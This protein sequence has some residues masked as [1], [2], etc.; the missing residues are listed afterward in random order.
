MQCVSGSGWSHLAARVSEAARWE[1]LKIYS[2]PRTPPIAAEQIRA[3]GIR[4]WNC[5]QV[6]KAIFPSRRI[7]RRDL[8][9][10]TRGKNRCKC[11]CGIYAQ[12]NGRVKER[13]RL[14]VSCWQL[15]FL[16]VYYFE[17]HQHLWAVGIGAFKSRLLDLSAGA[18]RTAGNNQIRQI[19]NPCMS[20][21]SR[22]ILT[23]FFTKHCYLYS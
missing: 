8:S 20:K 15:H 11:I 9:K 19:L 16:C 21:F 18:Q 4:A 6:F 14:L 2:S 13:S 17:H 7:T 22:W 10:Y 12:S 3:G 23:E 1:N 5:M